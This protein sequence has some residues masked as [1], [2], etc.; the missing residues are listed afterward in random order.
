MDASKSSQVLNIASQSKQRQ[1][2]SN[3]SMILRNTTTVD[4]RKPE[5]P[6]SQKIEI[7]LSSYSTTSATPRQ[8]RKLKEAEV[9]KSKRH[10][11]FGS[12]QVKEPR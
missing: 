8:K 6:G 12:R 10:C 9:N 2:S 1:S 4:Q 11:W 3:S 5:A 7:D